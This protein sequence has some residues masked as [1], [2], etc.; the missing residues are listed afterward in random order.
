MVDPSK[1]EQKIIGTSEIEILLVVETNDCFC[2]FFINAY[3]VAGYVISKSNGYSEMKEIKLI[4]TQN[5]SLF[6]AID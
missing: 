2:A 1:C 3:V 5:Y 6:Q 4:C